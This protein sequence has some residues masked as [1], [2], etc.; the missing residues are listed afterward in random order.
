MHVRLLPRY[1]VLGQSAGG[2]PLAINEQNADLRRTR[3]Y[4]YFAI[5][6]FLLGRVTRIIKVS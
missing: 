4:I 6:V 2:L 5:N 1:S 3:V